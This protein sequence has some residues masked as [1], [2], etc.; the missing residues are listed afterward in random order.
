MASA[1][2]PASPSQRAA[3]D[4]ARA[5]ARGDAFR[6]L[7]VLFVREIARALPV[8]EQNRDVVAGKAA[9]AKAVNDLFGLGPSGRDAEY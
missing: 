8:G 7:G 3:H 1:P 4:D 6:R 5:G 9:Q 2:M